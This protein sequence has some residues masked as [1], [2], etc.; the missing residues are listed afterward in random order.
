M[1]R[2]TFIEKEPDNLYT[3][4]YKSIFSSIYKKVLDKDLSELIT[5]NV[6]IRAKT[7]LSVYH[8]GGLPFSSW[9]Y[10]IAYNEI[11]KYYRKKR[12]EEK[13]VISEEML[14]KTSGECEGIDTL[15]AKLK[16]LQYKLD[17]KEVEL[18]L[19]RL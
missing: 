7:Y 6:L 17:I 2:L 11:M 13:V 5:S 8:S 15:R 3:K 1:N 16:V 4:Y 19:L 9:L 14:Y 10:M 12:K 18:M